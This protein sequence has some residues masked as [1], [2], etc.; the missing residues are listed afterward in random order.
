MAAASM[1]MA[2][3]LSPPPLGEALVGWV[4]S[5]AGPEALQSTGLRE[6][7]RGGPCF[8]SPRQRAIPPRTLRATRY[9][10]AA[11]RRRLPSHTGETPVPKLAQRLRRCPNAQCR[12]EALWE[13]R[14]VRGL[15]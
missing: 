15:S 9:G 14:C 2:E 4:A 7:H 8:P 3:G 10:Q 11:V 1:L 13:P 6:E 12:P 5:V